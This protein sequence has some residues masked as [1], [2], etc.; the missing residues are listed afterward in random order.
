[1]G[2]GLHLA[3]VQME[4]G[5][6]QR[7]A[8]AGGAGAGD[9]GRGR[10]QRRKLGHGVHGGF[11][12]AAA[13]VGVIGPQQLAL[14]AGQGQL[15]GGGACVDAKKAIALVCT[16]VGLGHHRVGVAGTEGVIFRLIREQRRQ[17]LDLK[18]HGDA[19]RQPVDQLPDRPRRRVRFRLQR[20]PHGGE[21]VG[22]VGVHD[23]FRRQLQ[24]A[25][26]GLFQL[27]QE[28]QRP[29]QKGHAAP[30]GLAAG[31]AR[32]GLVHHRLKDGGGQIGTGR[33]LVDE[34]LDVG[35][36]EH[37]APGGDGIQLLVVRRR[38]VKA[39]GV[40]LQQ[41]GHLVDEGAGAA[42]AHAVH[43]LLKAA[44]EIDDLGI[45]AAQFDGHIRPGIALLQRRGY[46]HHLLHEGNVQRPAQI[47]G[48]G[49]GDGGA[50]GAVAQ[51][52]AGLTQQRRQR[53]LGVGLMAAVIAVENVVVVVQYHQL[54][55]GRANV[56]T[57]TIG[58]HRYDIPP[59]GN[60]K[61]ILE[62]TIS[63]FSAFLR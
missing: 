19:L 35:L 37:A 44:G 57:G 40:G 33:A 28:V 11:D 20:R 2:D 51:H 30:D 55:G 41:G 61:I 25:D 56:D 5:L 29:A 48:A 32:D 13:V 16:Q 1:M 63:H 42:G 27:R 46:R 23:V 9:A 52:L 24:C 54:D 8:V 22:V 47:D 12:R 15:C 50:E 49:A 6:Q 36:G 31:K 38:V 18:G 39:L 21:Q 53:L 60:V 17:A 62:H 59:S 3:L 14:C 4:S 10:Q 26:K 58:F 45:L 7:F 43:P 34:G